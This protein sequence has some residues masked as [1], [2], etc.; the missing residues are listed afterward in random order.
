MIIKMINRKAYC[1]KDSDFTSYYSGQTRSGFG[2]IRIVRGPRYQ[3]GY[4]IGSFLSRLALPLIR[5]FGKEA[6][7]KGVSIGKRV[8]SDPQIQQAFKESISEL[9]NKSLARLKEQTG[10]GSKR[11]YKKKRKMKRKKLTKYKVVKNIVNK[12]PR[13]RDIF[14]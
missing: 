12:K 8:V 10:S 3:R 11:L 13:K 9:T 4:G 5:Q 6:L 14:N 7:S 2:D 1:P